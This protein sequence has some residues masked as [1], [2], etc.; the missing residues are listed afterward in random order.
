[1]QLLTSL[2]KD[3]RVYASTNPLGLN[4]P[5][6]E[7]QII[8][9]DD[10]GEGGIHMRLYGIHQNETAHF[11]LIAMDLIGFEVIPEPFDSDASEVDEQYRQCFAQSTEIYNRFLRSRDEADKKKS[12][13]RDELGEVFDHMKDLAS[14][15]AVGMALNLSTVLPLPE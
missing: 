2:F 15:Q 6:T 9:H 7:V 1:M 13:A 14:F 11:I 12:I 8:M 3:K 4:S 10:H 5:Q